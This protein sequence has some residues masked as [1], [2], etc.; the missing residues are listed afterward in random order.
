MDYRKNILEKKTNLEELMWSFWVWLTPWFQTSF[1]PETLI[2][3]AAE[4]RRL[5][6]F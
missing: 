5:C 6:C 3:A 1:V 4:S 2:L